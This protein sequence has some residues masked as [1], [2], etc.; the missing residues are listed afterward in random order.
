MGNEEIGIQMFCRV[1]YLASTFGFEF[2]ISVVVQPMVEVS[3]TSLAS[4]YY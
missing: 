3:H 1:R 4:K 2:L